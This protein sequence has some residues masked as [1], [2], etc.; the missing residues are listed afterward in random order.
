[1]RGVRFLVKV[2]PDGLGGFAGDDGGERLRRGLLHIAQAA[3]VREKAL[4]GLRAD[5]GNLQ[6]LGVSIPHGAALA[7][8]ADGEAMALVADELDE[9]QHRRAAVEDD[10]LVFVA[11]EVDDLFLFRDGGQRLRGE[12]E[13][14]ESVGCGVELAE[15]AV[16]EDE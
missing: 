10:G 6:Q 14:F 7:M 2:P 9:V 5:A 12:A 11:V 4:A 16:D 8:V 15:A 13:R 1:M 3:E